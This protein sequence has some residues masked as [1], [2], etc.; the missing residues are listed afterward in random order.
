MDVCWSHRPSPRFS[1]RVEFN[2][3]QVQRMIDEPTA[4]PFYMFN[5]IE[6]REQAVYADGRPTDLT[7]EEANALYNPGEYIAAIG[8][9]AVFSYRGSRSNRRR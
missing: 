1:L 5:L 4:G 6:Y 2:A 8:A 3:D 7:G 9:R